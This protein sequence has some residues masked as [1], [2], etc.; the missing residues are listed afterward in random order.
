[1]ENIQNKDIQ[2]L[3]DVADASWVPHARA[4]CNMVLFQ[5]HVVK[6]VFDHAKQRF[7]S[8]FAAKF[9]DQEVEKLAEVLKE[10]VKNNSELPT[11]WFLSVPKTLLAP[12]VLYR[13]SMKMELIS[14]QQII[15]NNESIASY[16]V[17]RL[18][19][20]LIFAYD[21]QYDALKREA[22][23]SINQF[24]HIDAAWL[25]AVFLNHKGLPGLH[26]H[27]NISDG[28]I[29]LAVFLEGAL[30]FYNTFNTITPEEVL[31]F[32]MFVSEQL[33]VNP[34]KDPYFYAGFIKKGDETYNLLIKYIKNLK[35]EDRPAQFSYCMPMLDISG[36]LFYNALSTPVCES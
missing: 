14:N 7:V 22:A 30:Q 5:N 29:S 20:Q 11:R 15:E 34:L 23:L 4:V 3:Y 21:E 19:A 33:K 8:L 9:N 27:F 2:V 26:L 31:Y 24:L 25:D 10:I 36:H 16:P 18:D 28:F 6:T 35:P 17:K 12:A 1:M 32:V 13:E